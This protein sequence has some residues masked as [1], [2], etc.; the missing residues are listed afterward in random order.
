MVK[1]IVLPVTK[2]EQVVGLN[3]EEFTK[4]KTVVVSGTPN[5]TS[6]SV[7]LNNAKVNRTPQPLSFPDF[8][9]IISI[10]YL[11]G[12]G[13]FLLRFS[14]NILY[15]VKYA[16]QGKIER[17]DGVKIVWVNKEISPF[18][19]MGYIFISTGSKEKSELPKIILHE[20]AG[21]DVSFFIA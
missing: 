8:A 5:T 3:I 4:A 15:M 19:F 13:F 17:I 14:A 2:Y 18:S 21:R 12:A 1:N 16:L 11:L 10:V 6:G 9:T 20:K 7:T